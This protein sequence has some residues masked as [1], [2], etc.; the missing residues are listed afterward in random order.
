ML[1]KN[2][3][4]KS[5]G[6]VTDNVEGRGV[7]GQPAYSPSFLHLKLQSS[8]SP[9]VKPACRLAISRFQAEDHTY[10]AGITPISS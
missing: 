3:V 5:V 10:I 4:G 9:F 2:A 8:L 7:A 6:I 1:R